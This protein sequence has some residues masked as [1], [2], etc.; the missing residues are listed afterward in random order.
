MRRADRLM[1]IVQI[2][3][4]RA[5]ATTAQML[6]DELEVVPRT[7]YRDIADLQG[8]GV[9][10]D[11]EAGVGYVLRQGYDLPPL[12]FTATEIDAIVIGARLVIARGDTQLAR[13][14]MDVLAKMSDVLPDKLAQQI[15]QST[16]YAPGRAAGESAESAAMPMVREA[17]RAHRKLTITYLDVKDDSS[18]R[19][20]WPLA[21]AYFPQ[22]TVLAAWC[23][24]RADY[25]AF[26][27]DRVQHCTLTDDRFDP[28]GGAM[29]TAFMEGQG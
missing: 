15:R 13:A 21:V 24:L 20:I 17:I 14:A 16:L 23:E 18:E 29:L 5:T 19:T 25:R 11:G 8:T 26:R 12:M 1:L 27:T 6:A 9:P 28:K 2:L 3:R 4:R 10:V 22:A 7:I